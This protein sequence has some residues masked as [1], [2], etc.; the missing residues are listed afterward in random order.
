M[1]YHVLPRWFEWW[2]DHVVLSLLVIAGMILNGLMFAHGIVSNIEDPA[3]WGVFHGAIFAAFFAA[4]SGLTGVALRASATMG[5]SFREGRRG[6][7]FVNL[8]VSLLFLPLEFWASV[9]ERSLTHVFTPADQWVLQFLGHP[10]M[11]VSPT[12]IAIALASPLILFSWGIVASPP[13][14][15]TAD[16]IAADMAKERARLEADIVLEPLR[17][18]KRAQQA[19]GLRSVAAATMGRELPPKPPSGGGSPV[20]Q[21]EEVAEEPSHITTNVVQLQRP[22]TKR[23]A[24]ARNRA[25]GTYP[26]G[27]RNPSVEAR[28]R[29]AWTGPDMSVKALERAAAISRSSAQKYHAK[30]SAEQAAQ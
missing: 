16:D 19:R 10:D 22:T 13:D 7:A 15:T 9:T 30:F 18:E 23:R 5:H 3:S 8:L 12:I 1:K 21:P 2:Q 11:P 4:G 24:A 27:L 14:E 26:R 28:A 17:A 20:Q 6:V 29:A 25:R